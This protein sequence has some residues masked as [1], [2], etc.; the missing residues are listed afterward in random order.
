MAAKTK[1]INPIPTGCPGPVKGTK[2]WACNGEDCPYG[3]YQ[4]A[5]C[6]QAI[7]DRGYTMVLDKEHEEQMRQNAELIKVSLQAQLQDANR[8]TSR[9]AEEIANAQHALIV[10]RDEGDYKANLYAREMYKAMIARHQIDELKQTVADE[11]DVHMQDCEQYEKHIAL[12]LQDNVRLED[13]LAY[14]R[15]V[16]AQ[17][18]TQSEEGEQ[19][20]AGIVSTGD[21][22]DSDSNSTDA[23]VRD[24]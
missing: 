16:L 1:H 19:S 10:L 5:C 20:T 6:K 3:S 9:Y 12:L 11:H 15:Q 8:M 7:A 23:E 22:T 18:E 14:N 13:E 17:L 21:N 24:A 2:L 4:Y